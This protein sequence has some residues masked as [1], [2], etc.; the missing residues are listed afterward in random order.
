[1][2]AP[3]SEA[4]SNAWIYTGF[5]L[6]GLVGGAT[7][8]VAADSERLRSKPW[9]L[10]SLAVLLEAVLLV[11]LP[12]HM[13][14][15][16]SRSTA[17]LELA[18]VTGIWGV[19]FVVWFANFGLALLV[20][21]HRR[22]RA[23]LCLALAV[24]LS[25]TWAPASTGEVRVAMIQTSTEDVDELKQL[26]RAG[27][28]AG[29]TVAVWP[30]LSG[31]LAVTDGNTDGLAAIASVPGQAAFVTTFE[32]PASP[33]PYN[34]ARLFGRGYTSP[35][36]RKRKP[37]AG[38]A[39]MHAAGSQPAATVWNGTGYGLNIC[40]DSCFPAVMRDTARQ[41]GVAAIL[42]PTLD[43]DTPYGVIQAIHAAYTPFR[44]AELGMPIVRADTTA[45][46]MAVDARGRTVAQAGLGQNEIRVAALRPERRWTLARAAGDW[47][48]AVAAIAFAFGILN[49]RSKR[50]VKQ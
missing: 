27:Y 48:L 40:F 6:F 20:S 29:A 38:E 18:S 49:G 24:A 7:I 46:S 16:Q 30:E 42:L 26:N 13:A 35:G 10:A 1:M 5:V 2:L 28:R 44:A 4:G 9:C 37:F 21:A 14:L 45:F 15:T 36:Y 39:Q 34:V 31:Q 17:M 22:R 25:I 11:Y 23:A 8:G 12:A 33:L 41:A 32:E 19:S 43:P 47:F 3:L 50:P